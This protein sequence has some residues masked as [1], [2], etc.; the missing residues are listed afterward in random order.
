MD[1]AAKEA[2]LQVP[3]AT[4]SYKLRGTGPLL[5][6]L[7][8][9]AADAD[10]CDAFVQQ[11]AGRYQV[12]TYDRRGLSRSK[13]DD[14]LAA[15]QIE[16]H[17]EDVHL[18]L[19]A[20]TNEPALV[21]G[22]SIGALIGLDLVTRHPQQVRALVALEPAALQLLPDAERTLAL[23][24]HEEVQQIFRR[25]GVLLAMRKMAALA[26]VNFDDREPDVDL[27]PDPQRAPIM[28][29]NMTFFLTH[30][31]PAAHRY[32][33]NIP[34]LKSASTRI[35]LGVGRTSCEITPRQCTLV[36]ANL[37]GTP[38]TEFPGGHSGYV[39]RPREFASRLHEVLAAAHH[40]ST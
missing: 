15:P 7:Q 39:F 20:L 33:L 32:V 34:A 21:L 31:A 40:A 23:E 4:L 17:S 10:G 13:Q 27:R 18:L 22:V 38:V 11:L 29:A 28:P 5:L 1:T 2:T 19:A 14:P 37:L 12:V 26:G 16:T 30:D 3:G 24:A 25:D 6:I 9:G 35:I 36:L 8:G